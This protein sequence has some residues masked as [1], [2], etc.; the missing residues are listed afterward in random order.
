M[1]QTNSDL[2]LIQRS[3]NFCLALL[4]NEQKYA[5]PHSA[6]GIHTSVLRP[7]LARAD[8]CWAYGIDSG[9]E[10]GQ[11]A[12]GILTPYKGKHRVEM[13][14]DPVS[15]HE[16]FW[17]ARGGKRGSIV[18]TV[19]LA[20]FP[21]AVFR[22]CLGVH[23]MDN[24]RAGHTPAAVKFAQQTIAGG[25][26]IAV[27]LPRNNGIEWAELFAPQPMVFELYAQARAACGAGRPQ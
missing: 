17:N 23:V 15:G 10:V 26:H 11:A 3:S 13:A 24:Y 1:T 6:Y 19:P 20:D 14:G 12:R 25:T 8:G 7:L 5:D 18:I 16:L 27:C 21:V 4:D 22:A 9:S 2:A